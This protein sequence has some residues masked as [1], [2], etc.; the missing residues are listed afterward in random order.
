MQSHPAPARP[1]VAVAVLR[2]AQPLEEMLEHGSV[3]AR[4][5]P[6]R[7]AVGGGEGAEIVFRRSSGGRLAVEYDAR[8]I[9]EGELREDGPLGDILGRSGLSS[10]VF[11]PA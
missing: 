3:R 8:A 10:V 11:R 6:H 4:A 2:D 5:A 7:I 9:T 1:A